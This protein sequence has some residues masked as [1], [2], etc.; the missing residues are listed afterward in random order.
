MLL[1]DRS[2]VIT[3]AGSGVGRASAR[4]FAKEGARVV[5]ADLRDDWVKETVQLIE[6]DGGTAIAQHCDVTV[7]DDVR[8]SVASA[9]DQFGRL[10]VMF[11][12]V[13]VTARGSPAFEDHSNE[14]WE[15]LITVNVRSVFWGCKYA[16]IRFKEQ[17]GGG[18]IV[19][20]GSASGLVGWGGPPYGATKGAVHSLSRTLAMEVA[21]F[22]IRV[23]CICPGAM[24][25]T[26]FAVPNATRGSQGL[27]EE[28]GDRLGTYHP[29]GRPITAEDCAGA[30][31]YLSSDLASNV[32]G[33]LFPVD[34]GYT[35]R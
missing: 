16:V 25:F 34:G 4:L 21:P 9:V 27:G 2:A 13:G 32:T 28:A 30:A 15:R 19:N 8:A 5:C 10:D 24:P 17:G 20:T 12:N 14:E 31:L 6:A 18:S 11:N 35:A 1:R 29:L 26:N 33:V 7:E 23:N 3:G 22:N